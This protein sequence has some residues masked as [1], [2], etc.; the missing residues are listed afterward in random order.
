MLQYEKIIA[1]IFKSFRYAGVGKTKLLKLLWFAHRE[2]M[3]EYKTP[4]SNLEFLK[5][6]FGPVPKK[7][8]DIIEKMIKNNIIKEVQG[9]AN[10]IVYICDNL[11]I[12]TFTPQEINSLE[13]CIN[14]YGKFSAKQLSEMSHDTQWQALE[15]GQTMLPEAVF[16]RDLVEISDNEVEALKAKYL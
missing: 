1:Y 5:M 16:L 13:K 8:E 6:K 2:F 11:E 12:D 4:L 7:Y 14:T 15:I 9:R 10:N 3:Y